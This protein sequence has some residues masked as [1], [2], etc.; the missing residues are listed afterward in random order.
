MKETGDRCERFH[1]PKY[2]YIYIYNIDVY[3]R[4]PAYA[5]IYHQ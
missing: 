4:P 1:I 5:V 2:I 3:R